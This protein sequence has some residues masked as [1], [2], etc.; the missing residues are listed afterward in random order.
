M[1]H[2][3]YNRS[4]KEVGRGLD[5]RAMGRVAAT[6][7]NAEA[8]PGWPGTPLESVSGRAQ[9]HPLDLEDRRSV[10]RLARPVSPVPDL[11]PSVPAV[12]ANGGI[13]AT[14]Q[15][16]GGGCAGSGWPGSVRMLHRRDVRDGQKR[17]RG[18]GATKRG[19]GSKIMVV[20]DRAGLPL[21]LHVA[22][23]SP[24]EVTLVDQTLAARFVR[25]LPRRLIGDKAYDSDPLD[26]QLR[27][28][29]LELIAPHKANRTKPPTQDGRPLRRYRHRWKVERL[30]SWLNNC[31]RLTV[32][33]EYHVDNFLGLLH[34]ACVLIL[35]KT[36]L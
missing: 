12:G 18:V 20:A 17:G 26:A 30:F 4:N 11:P 2:P 14:A 9:R 16:R 21:A 25:P 7:P 33:Y 29:G 22:A 28:R 19:K 36:Y 6:D 31:R 15:S 5:G 34:L 8:S 23:A 24:Q 10:A 13:G 35:L 27:I 1:V 3:L 32:R